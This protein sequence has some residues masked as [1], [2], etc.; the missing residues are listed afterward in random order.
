MMIQ[1]CDDVVKAQILFNKMVDSCGPKCFRKL[2]TDAIV[3]HTLDEFYPVVIRAA[4]SAALVLSAKAKEQNNSFNALEYL[5]KSFGLKPHHLINLSAQTIA[6]IMEREVTDVENMLQ[7][8]D[9]V[10]EN[11][12]VVA[13]PET[14]KK[15][16]IR[17]MPLPRR[18][19]EGE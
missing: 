6:D 4:N 11:G 2:F 10:V 7:G 5:E 12:V 19:S 8:L 13:H 17:F 1:A 3:Q 16:K 9:F 15:T 18:R 14:G